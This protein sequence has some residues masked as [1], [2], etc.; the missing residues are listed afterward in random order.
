M[1]VENDYKMYTAVKWLQS[2]ISQIKKRYPTTHLL[3]VVS[4]PPTERE[5]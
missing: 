1:V 2:A 3:E 5:E 4:L